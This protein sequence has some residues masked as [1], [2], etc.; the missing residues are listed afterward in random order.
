MKKTLLL[1]LLATLA[2][3][4]WTERPLRIETR[5][6]EIMPSVES[7]DIRSS[8]ATPITIYTSL[9]S[10]ATS[11]NGSTTLCSVTP[12]TTWAAQ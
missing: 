3:T 8:S 2:A 9:T 12:T 7:S 1:V 11:I 4:V 10:A 6:P 5:G